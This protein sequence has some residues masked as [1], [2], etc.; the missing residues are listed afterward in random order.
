MS[1]H[2]EENIKYYLQLRWGIIMPPMQ[3]Q[4]E[5]NDSIGPK[6]AMIGIVL[7]IIYLV[8]VQ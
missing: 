2:Y 7:M 8:I 1:G 6:L 3:S 5:M 4:K